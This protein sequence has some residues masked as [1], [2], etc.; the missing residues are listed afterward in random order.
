[1]MDHKHT[2]GD[3]E[4]ILRSKKEVKWYMALLGIRIVAFVLCLIAF[5]MLGANEQKVLVNEEITNWF[6]IGISVKT[7]YEFRW[8][9]YDEFNFSANVIGFVYSGLQICYLVKY[10]ITKNHTINPKLQGYFNVAFEQTLA[11]VLISASSSA[12]TAAHLYKSYW[13]EHGAHKFIE[14]ADASVAIS[15]FAFVTFALASLVSGF[16]LFRFTIT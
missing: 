11:Y 1:M 14:M 3:S 7:P 16:I 15:F 4:A 8:Y 9:D 13:I 5:Y 6:S 12:A 10:L 2:S